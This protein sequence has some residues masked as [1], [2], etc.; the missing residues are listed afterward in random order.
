M[1]ADAI[2]LGVGDDFNAGVDAGV[3][4]GLAAGV[5]FAVELVDVPG[6]V[7][8]LFEFRLN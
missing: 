7:V 4:L 1:V 5:A 3:A 6:P 8:F 2:G